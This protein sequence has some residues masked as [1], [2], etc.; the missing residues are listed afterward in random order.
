MVHACLELCS[1]LSISLPYGHLHG[2]WWKNNAFEQTA[3]AGS[4]TV[5]SWNSSGG[6]CCHRK[7]NTSPW[8]GLNHCI[9]QSGSGNRVL[10]VSRAKP[11]MIVFGSNNFWSC[12]GS[13]ERYTEASQRRCDCG[14]PC[15]YAAAPFTQRK[16]SISNC[17]IPNWGGTLHIHHRF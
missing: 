13:T 2:I 1:L 14:D 16:N 17:G 8:E 7:G 9:W 3:E 10:E 4:Q 6:L 12:W 15:W 5:L 11:S